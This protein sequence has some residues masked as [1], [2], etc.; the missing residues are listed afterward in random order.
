MGSKR[1]SKFS[2]KADHIAKQQLID[3]EKIKKENDN[4][5]D[6]IESLF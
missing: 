4:L 2:N 6:Q 1:E 5:L 3:I